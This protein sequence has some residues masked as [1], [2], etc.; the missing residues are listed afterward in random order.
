[1]GDGLG[2]TTSCLLRSLRR[3]RA[4]P[5]RSPARIFPSCGCDPLQS[6]EADPTYRLIVSTIPV[7]ASAHPKECRTFRSSASPTTHQAEARWRALLRL[8]PLQGVTRTARRRRIA[9]M[10]IGR[11]L[12]PWSFA[13]LRRLS[14]SESA[15]ELPSRDVPPSGFLTLSTDYSS[16][17]RPALF[18]AGN[19]LG[20]SLF[21]GFPPPSAPSRS[22]RPGCPLGVLSSHPFKT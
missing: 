13:S 18:H 8:R 22:S 15:C 14:T 1:L 11:Q 3:I 12:L 2:Q 4:D 6:L 21:R 17:A 16:P 9:A 10:T 19:A 7:R 5:S 20:I